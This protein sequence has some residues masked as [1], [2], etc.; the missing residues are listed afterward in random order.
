MEELN[1]R[2]SPVE[3]LIEDVNKSLIYTYDADGKPKKIKQLI[4]NHEI[5]ME[6][7]KR[8]AGKIRYNEFSH[9]IFLFGLV[10]WEDQNNCR[11]WSSHDD[12]ALFSLMQADYGLNSRQ[13]FF[14][15]L[16]NTAM[17]HRFHPI[18]DLLNSFQWDGKEHIRGLLPEFL[19][20]EDSEYNRQVMCLWMLGAVARIYQPGCKF[21]YTMI[22]QGKQGIGKSTFLRLM[23]LDDAWF[24]DSLDSLDSDKA[25]QSLTGSW[26]IELAELKSLARTAG[27]SESIKRF[28][29]ATQDKYRIPYERRADTF[30]RQCVFAG[31]TNRADF[32][33]DETGNR[34]FLI[35]QIGFNE[36]SK[37]LFD[38]TVMDEIK[39]AW[40]EAVYIWK[41][42]KPT[43]IL[44]E[45]LKQEA[46]QAQND[47]MADDGSSGIIEAYLED[48]TKVC[49]IQVWQEALGQSGT[50]PKWKAAEINS[51]IS[52]VPGWA[53]IKNVSRFGKYG[54]QRGY[55]KVPTN[56][57]EFVA[58]DAEQ[59]SELP[60][61]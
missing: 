27:G 42:E 34:R 47:N 5:V 12:S 13:D 7:D 1:L 30:Y 37:S 38:S 49:A 46:E 48:Q 35:V 58:V 45:S 4:K 40:A 51:I 39:Q 54:S 22:L 50:P 61:D 16:R 18:K 28:L 21:D 25:V 15:A 41:N 10:P 33:Q 11:V 56:K 43:L 23:A 20:A 19:G 52:K 32:L 2:D 17:R 14:D 36:P 55:E 9:Q 59:Q 60:F 26:I 44:P 6:C 8:I 29:T 31:T 3:Q 24:N 53:K 57:N